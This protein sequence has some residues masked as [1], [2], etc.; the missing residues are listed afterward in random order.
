MQGYAEKEKLMSQPRRMLI[1]SFELANG[2]IITS[3]LLFYL[4]LGLLCTIVYCFVV[5][6]P[7]KDLNNFVKTTVNARCQRDEIANP[8][9][10]VET[11]KVLAN[12]LY[13]YQFMDD[14]RQSVTR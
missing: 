1:S 14:S 13:G 11:M 4:E 3:S 6:T 9:V 2:R 12:S 7:V 8:N 10:I 5:Y